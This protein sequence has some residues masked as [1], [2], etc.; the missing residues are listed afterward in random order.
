MLGIVQPRSQGL[1]FLV[2][3]NLSPSIRLIAE[4]L[5]RIKAG[6][7]ECWEAVETIARRLGLSKRTVQ[8]GLKALELEG[9]VSLV[10]DT[11]LR[12]GRRIVML[13][14]QTDE[15][16]V[17][18]TQPEPKQENAGASG[19]PPSH[20]PEKRSKPGP[21]AEGRKASKDEVDKVVRKA[22]ALFCCPMRHQV[23]KL[24]R[25]S[26]LSWVDAAL[27]QAKKYDAESWGYV[28][29][30]IHAWGPDGPPP[31]RVRWQDNIKSAVARMREILQERERTTPNGMV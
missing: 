8:R 25:Q 23:E 14:R 10:K 26:R 7:K 11:T 16:H 15:H 9:L 13:W 20:E 12:T 3:T 19:P 4:Y 5:D 17:V 31:K 27:D 30:L 24:A 28:K 18:H 29:T 22:E 6:V 21:T 2:H 1:G